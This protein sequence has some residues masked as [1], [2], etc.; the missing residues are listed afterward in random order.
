MHGEPLSTALYDGADDDARHLRSRRRQGR[1]RRRKKSGPPVGAA[2]RRAAPRR[3]G[4]A[5]D[6][7]SQASRP[8]GRQHGGDRAAWR[9]VAGI[10]GI[11]RGRDAVARH[12]GGAHGHPFRARA[13]ARSSRS[14]GSP[15]SSSDIA[16]AMAAVDVR[17]LAPIPG[18]S[19][20]GVEVPNHKRQLVALGDLMAHGGGVGSGASAAGRDRQGHRRA[21]R[22]PRPLHHAPPADRRCHRRRQ[23]ER[24]QLHH[25][26]VADAHHARPGAPD[27]D[28]SQ[29]GRDGAVPAPPT[30]AHAAGHQPEE[31][32][33]RPRMGGQGDGA[34]LRRAV[35]GRVPRHHG[36]QRGGA[37]GEIEPPPGLAA[38]PRRTSTCRTS[39]WWS[40]SS[41]T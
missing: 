32:R 4:V 15:A 19:A 31:G 10:A 9:H 37:K 20:I 39:S 21:G 8:A 3:V 12:D 7:L 22:V 26:L 27:P 16:Y 1:K 36:L 38:T 11:A 24:D 35:G 14:L 18:R 33:Q 17:I 5:A 40:T 2:D 34:S 41:T 30:P 25:H 28:R 6:Q 29:A 13:R 23:V